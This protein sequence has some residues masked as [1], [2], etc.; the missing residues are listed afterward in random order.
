MIAGRAFVISPPP[1]LLLTRRQTFLDQFQFIRRSIFIAALNPYAA[2]TGEIE[3]GQI[4]PYSSRP[5]RPRV[6]LGDKLATRYYCFSNGLI[7]HSA[8]I[9]F[10]SHSYN[11]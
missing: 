7:T 9:H 11:A 8:Y 2:R 1:L 5:I 6:D 3:N 4:P 10:G